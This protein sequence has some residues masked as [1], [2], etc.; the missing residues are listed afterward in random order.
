[1]DRL[2]LFVFN[3]TKLNS[4]SRVDLYVCVSMCVEKKF[5]EIIFS[6][7]TKVMKIRPSRRREKRV[8]EREDFVRDMRFPD[9][10]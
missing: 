2:R 5:K 10:F 3:A 4:C 7:L 9:S 6:Y 8:Y 1:M